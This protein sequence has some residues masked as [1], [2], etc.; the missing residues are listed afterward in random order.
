MPVTGHQRDQCLPLHISLC[1]HDEVSPQSQLAQTFQ[2]L[3]TLKFSPEL[4][5]KEG[6]SL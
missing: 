1:D 4:L 5:F 6:K 2:S 3:L